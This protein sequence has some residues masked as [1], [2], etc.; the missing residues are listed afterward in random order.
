VLVGVEVAGDDDAGVGI[1][2]EDPVDQQARFEGLPRAFGRG[3]PEAFGP[4]ADRSPLEGP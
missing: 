3:D 1:G 2:V 4:A